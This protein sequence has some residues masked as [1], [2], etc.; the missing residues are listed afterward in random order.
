[1]TA[2]CHLHQNMN[3]Y[4]QVPYIRSQVP[5]IYL[6]VVV[7][8]SSTYF[9][10]SQQQFERQ[11]GF[12]REVLTYQSHPNRS[13]PREDN[14]NYSMSRN[15][16]NMNASTRPA[17]WTSDKELSKLPIVFHRARVCTGRASRL[18]IQAQS[19]QYS[20]TTRL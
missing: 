3:Q 17:R 4:V 19:S 11:I 14:Y 5:G 10:T 15:L 2:L 9:L 16:Q 12:K 7:P 18:L 8:A 20:K 13:T 6:R 1:M